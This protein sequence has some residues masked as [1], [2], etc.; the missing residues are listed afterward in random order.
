MSTG[1]ERSVFLQVPSQNEDPF[2]VVCNGD[3]LCEVGIPCP[4]GL[5]VFKVLALG[6][7]D[8]DF[9]AIADLVEGVVESVRFWGCLDERNKGGQR[10]SM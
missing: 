10:T 6:E 3:F 7:N 1:F 8:I 5:K 4:N 9:E 2:T